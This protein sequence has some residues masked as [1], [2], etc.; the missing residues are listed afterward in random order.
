[1]KEFVVAGVQ[2]AVK[3]NDVEANIEKGL[4][5][6]EKAVKLGAELIV[7]P[8]TI[9]TG[10]ATGLPKEKLW[11][12]VDFIPGKT[13]EK[14]QKAA[15]EYGVY[16]IWPTY[17]RGPERGIVY[18]SAPLIGRDGEIIGVYRKTHPFPSEREWTTPGD[19]AE[20][21]KTDIANIGII[22]CY[23]GD[24][25]DLATTLKGL[26]NAKKP[27]KIR[28][29]KDIRDVFINYNL[30]KT[31]KLVTESFEKLA[32]RDAINHI[33]Q[34]VSDFFWAYGGDYSKNLTDPGNLEAL[35]RF[36][37]FLE[38]QADPE[39][40]IKK[41]GDLKDGINRNADIQEFA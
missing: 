7:F 20:V 40:L 11:D 35:Q 33:I 5:W 13:T 8:E 41:Y 27:E 26:K 34:F 21:F 23:D 32:I 14:I 38:H 22:I 24:F 18:N 36:F 6:I 19:K 31:I 3:P 1:M 37:N 12:L 9:T 39:F 2:M 4:K 16:I 30:N 25:P 29:E 10:F 28:K 15:E 17:E